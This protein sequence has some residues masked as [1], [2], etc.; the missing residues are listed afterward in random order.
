M[1]S[2]I[3]L[4][5]HMLLLIIVSYSFLASIELPLTVTILRDS[6]AL[7]NICITLWNTP[8]SFL[9]G[10]YTIRMTDFCPGSIGRFEYSALVHV[11]EVMIRLIFGQ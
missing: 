8:A 2:T 11:H 6:S 9:R 3:A 7:V 10:S 4:S 5:I 1:G